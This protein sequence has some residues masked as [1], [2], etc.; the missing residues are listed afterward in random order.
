MGGLRAPG[1]A[2]R[3]RLPP[4]A[5]HRAGRSGSD[6]ATVLATDGI[7]AAVRA[8]EPRVVALAER[9]LASGLA[10]STDDDLA[11]AL[12]RHWDLIAMDD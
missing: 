12:A 1:R 6:P 5:G 10:P 9:L 4:P 11:T 8:A 2:Q 3:L 7:V